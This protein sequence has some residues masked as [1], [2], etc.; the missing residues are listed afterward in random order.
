MKHVRSLLSHRWLGAMPA[1]LTVLL[2][3]PTPVLA[4]KW[5]GAWVSPG[6]QSSGGA[7]A[8]VFSSV[9]VPSINGGDAGI[10]SVDMGMVEGI[11]LSAGSRIQL[12][13]NL[14]VTDPNGEDVTVNS[15]YTTELENARLDVTVEFVPLSSRGPHGAHKWKAFD[16]HKDAGNR[17]RTFVDNR[18]KTHLL[19]QGSDV[20]DGNYTLSVTIEY[21][22]KGHRNRVNGWNNASPHTF[23][24]QGTA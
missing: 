19:R 17:E 24:F 2:L 10:L 8:P 3:A 20:N 22:T 16:F 12:F 21:S 15:R 4:F 7:P 18:S 9:D 6:G 13:R 23:T 1:L 14:Q 5:T 11:G